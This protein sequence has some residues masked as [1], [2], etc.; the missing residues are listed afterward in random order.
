MNKG[1]SYFFIVQRAAQVSSLLPT[2][3]CPNYPKSPDLASKATVMEPLLCPITYLIPTQTLASVTLDHLHT[4]PPW[5]F[6]QAVLS[7][8]YTPLAHH[9]LYTLQ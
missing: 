9:C 7:A 3:I 1:C 5:A 8:E 2:R 6:T 4:F